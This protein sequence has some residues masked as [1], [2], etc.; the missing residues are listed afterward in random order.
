[1]IDYT[2][3]IF[4]VCVYKILVEFMTELFEYKRDNRSIF[5]KISRHKK[6]YINFK[7]YLEELN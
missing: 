7:F 4:W 6:W 1:M 3:D 2:K 5:I